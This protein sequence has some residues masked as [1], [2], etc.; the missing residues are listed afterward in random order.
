MKHPSQSAARQ[1]GVALVLVLAMLVL[2]SAL[3]VAFVTSAGTEN[4]ASKTFAQGL[5]ARQAAETATNLVIAQIR[6]AT[7]GDGIN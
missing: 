5:E 3:L 1:D 7:K 4:T 6:E 2:M